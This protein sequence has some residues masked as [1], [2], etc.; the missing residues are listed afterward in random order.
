MPLS[1]TSRYDS[2]NLGLRPNVLPCLSLEIWNTLVHAIQFNFAPLREIQILKCIKIRIRLP[3]TI[4]S[5]LQ[6]YVRFIEALDQRYCVHFQQQELS[7]WPMNGR[8]NSCMEFKSA[9]YVSLSVC[10]LSKS[11]LPLFCN[12]HWSFN[13]LRIFVMNH[14]K[15]VSRCQSGDSL[16]GCCLYYSSYVQTIVFI[17]DVGWHK[18]NT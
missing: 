7:L 5:L 3:N 10:L 6:E 12:L 13:I 2:R 16:G 11:S 17:V 15:P 9:W 14:L 1:F 18:H 8:K 4:T